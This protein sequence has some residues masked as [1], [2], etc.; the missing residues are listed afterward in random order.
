MTAIEME[1]QQMAHKSCFEKIQDACGLYISNL[2]NSFH[3]KQAYLEK[4][5]PSYEMPKDQLLE[6]LMIGIFTEFVEKDF[7]FQQLDEHVKD[8]MR[9]DYRIIKEELERDQQCLEN[10]YA[11]YNYM[12]LNDEAASSDDL[13]IKKME[14]LSA[15]DIADFKKSSV[16]N[17]IVMYRKYF[18]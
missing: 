18:S 12:L 3:R 10:R 4:L 7:R 16:L 9:N 1:K 13:K 11:E 15:V 8:D 2:K 6:D 5:I 17:K 14:Y